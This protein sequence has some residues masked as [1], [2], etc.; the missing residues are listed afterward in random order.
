MSP[1]EL[2][3]SGSNDSNFSALISRYFTPDDLKN[4]CNVSRTFQACFNKYEYWC[5]SFPAQYKVGAKFLKELGD[6]DIAVNKLALA[7]SETR[8][9]QSYDR[10]QLLDH[11]PFAPIVLMLKSQP[12]GEFL[13]SYQRSWEFCP[14][15]KRPLLY[16]STRHYLFTALEQGRDSRWP[17]CL[18]EVLEDPTVYPLPKSFSKEDRERV[19]LQ[20]DSVELMQVYGLPG[21][22]QR[23]FSTSNCA[24]EALRATHSVGSLFDRAV[25]R[26]LRE[27]NLFSPLQMG[28]LLADDDMSQAARFY[29]TLKPELACDSNIF[30]PPICEII[31]AWQNGDFESLFNGVGESNIQM[32]QAII[33]FAL[34]EGCS[35]NAVSAVID[36][37]LISCIAG[38]PVI[39][40]RWLQTLHQAGAPLDYV[41]PLGLNLADRNYSMLSQE[42]EIDSNVEARKLQVWLRDNGIWDKKSIYALER[43]FNWAMYSLDENALWAPPDPSVRHQVALDL[44]RKVLALG[45]KRLITKFLLRSYFEGYINV[46]TLHQSLEAG[47]KNPELLDASD[48]DMSSQAD[49]VK[50]LSELFDECPEIL[51]IK[52]S[53]DLYKTLLEIVFRAISDSEDSGRIWQEVKPLLPRIIQFLEEQKAWYTMG[54]LFGAFAWHCCK[55]GHPFDECMALFKPEAR[56]AAT[57]NAWLSI[58]LL[59]WKDSTINVTATHLQRFADLVKMIPA[60]CFDTGIASYPLLSRL[61]LNSH[62]M[63]ISSNA[64]PDACSVWADIIDLLISRSRTTPITGKVV[65]LTIE[66]Q[67]LSNIIM[68]KRFLA[69][70]YQVGQGAV[71]LAKLHTQEGQPPNAVTFLLSRKIK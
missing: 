63:G 67:S 33:S 2:F 22:Q 1:I 44:G 42:N 21:W 71:N 53:K 25:E 59:Y 55:S 49:F 51:L 66:H 32:Q 30:F 36:A 14:K 70:G 38:D 45:K 7:L 6:C 9:L 15:E 16:K 61:A 47:L 19:A 23:S 50:I 58:C 18:K 29:R 43:P 54:G 13:L 46:K 41:T 5:E 3:I 52:R 4:T 31:Q 56:D 12:A 24:L 69:H 10:H 65:Q 17:V 8:Q 34:Q 68:L 40:L 20:H 26:L 48:I 60:E 35:P 27:P 39:E 28:S 62:Y 57:L 37:P 64:T 11:L